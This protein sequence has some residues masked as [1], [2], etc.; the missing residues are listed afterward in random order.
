MPLIPSKNDSLF[1]SQMAAMEFHFHEHT[2]T[3][4]RFNRNL[5]LCNEKI[6]L[7]WTYNK[8]QTG[9]RR[10]GPSIAIFDFW[11]DM[12]IYLWFVSERKKHVWAAWRPKMAI[13]TWVTNWRDLSTAEVG[14]FDSLMAFDEIYKSIGKSSIL[15]FIAAQKYLFAKQFAV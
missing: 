2:W 6:S 15:F 4:K 9:S 8:M 12:E 11:I 5:N 7:S 1:I 3:H 13:E 14:A 10:P